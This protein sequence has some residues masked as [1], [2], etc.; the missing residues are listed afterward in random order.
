M[1]TRYVSA[2]ARQLHVIVQ[3]MMSGNPAS[4]YTFCTKCSVRPFRL[5]R[6]YT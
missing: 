2:A 5:T 1:D 3:L 6:C 4:P